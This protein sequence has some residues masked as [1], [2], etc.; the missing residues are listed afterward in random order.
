MWPGMKPRRVR[1]MFTRKSAPQPA[2]RNTASGGTDTRVSV[3]PKW[4]VGMVKREGK[5]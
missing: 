2:M 3:D 1:Q 5:E 4:F